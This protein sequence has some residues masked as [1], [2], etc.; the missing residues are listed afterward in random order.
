MLLYKSS[1]SLDEGFAW[2]KL[3]MSSCLILKI[4]RAKELPSCQS[5][6]N[7]PINVLRFINPYFP[8]TTL[9]SS[10]FLYANEVSSQRGY[11]YNF[12]VVFCVLLVLHG[13][14][15]ALSETSFYSEQ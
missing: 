15:R 10:F 5:M 3:S 9:V 14:L 11:Q 4:S 2:V 8:F 12:N 1:C 6:S 7:F 13:C